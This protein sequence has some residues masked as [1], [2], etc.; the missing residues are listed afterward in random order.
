M[1]DVVNN[2]S[3]RTA[4]FADAG[5]GLPA[6][7]K[8]EIWGEELIEKQVKSSAKSGRVYLPPDWVGHQVKIIRID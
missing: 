8:F 4:E 3:D 2:R 7:T 6:K 5:C 1:A